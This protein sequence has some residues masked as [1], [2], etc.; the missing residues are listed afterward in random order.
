[1]Y[2]RPLVRPD[3]V[4]PDRIQL[5]GLKLCMLSIDD[6]ERDFEAVV[7]SETWLKG[8]F[9]QESPLPESKTPNGLSF[10]ALIA[11]GHVQDQSLK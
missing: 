7:A 3:F 5:D 11:V 8:L 10:E 2:N 6:V 4:V 9:D 1:M